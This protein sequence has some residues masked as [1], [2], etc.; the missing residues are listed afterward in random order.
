LSR[1][2]ALWPTPKVLDVIEESIFRKPGQGSQTFDLEAY[3]ELL[4]LYAVA[5]ELVDD[6]RQA[7]A[8]AVPGSPVPAVPEVKPLTD[9][10][11]ERDRPDFQS[12]NIQPLPVASLSGERGG[13][14]L[15]QSLLRV[16]PSPNLGLD[17]DLSELVPTPVPAPVSHVE[18]HRKMSEPK[19]PDSHLIDFDLFDMATKAHASSKRGR[20]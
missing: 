11:G 2:T 19:A 16:P 15:S 3:R 9:L 4:M 20:S 18:G 1:I 6:G 13:D 7:R 12:T 14:S 17:I 10:G 5:K 8:V